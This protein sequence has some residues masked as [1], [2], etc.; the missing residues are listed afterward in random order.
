[1]E[2]KIVK[3]K[4]DFKK[5]LLLP[6]KIYKGNPNWVPPLLMGLK[7]VLSVKK[8]PFWQHACREFF[9]AVDDK[10]ETIGRIAGIWDENHNKVYNEKMGFFG[11]FESINDQTVANALFDAAHNWCKQQGMEHFRGPVNPNL[12]EECG[13]L[14]DGFDSPPVGMMT[15]NPP[16]YIDLYEKYG[17]KKLMNLLA[18]YKA[19]GVSERLQ[20][21][22]DWANRHKRFKIRTMDMKHFK[23]DVGIIRDMYNKAWEKNWGFVPMT[24]AEMDLMAKK[25]KPIC[26]PELVTFAETEG[27]IVGMGVSIPNYNEVLIHLN[28]RL[29]PWGIL[30]FLWYKRKIKGVRALI[31]GVLPEYQQSGLAALLYRVTEDNAAKLGVEWCELSWELETNKAVNAFIDGIGGKLYKTYRLYQI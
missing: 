14:V 17:L 7:S 8:N 5:F 11:Y 16:Y 25:L 21:L 9:I 19:K 6:W 22:C 27:K 3:T 10:G 29:T 30:K 4:K 18:F 1:M 26:I 20:K 31:Y 28:G 15:Y 23:R 2:I 12:N 13:L 24:D